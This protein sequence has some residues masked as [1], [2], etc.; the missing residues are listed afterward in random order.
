MQQG[1]IS[2]Y[3]CHMRWMGEELSSSCVS[4]GIDYLRVPER[5]RSIKCGDKRGPVS[6]DSDQSMHVYVERSISEGPSFGILIWCVSGT[7]YL[8]EA[9]VTQ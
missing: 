4:R 7:C 1:M 8:S 2:A 5:R 3:L 9:G 6:S